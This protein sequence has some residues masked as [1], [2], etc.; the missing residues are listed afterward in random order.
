[1]SDKL[2]QIDQLQR[3][4]TDEAFKAAGLPADGWAR[5]LFGPLLKPPTRRFARLASEFD[6]TVNRIGLSAAAGDFLS[7]FVEGVVVCG[8]E[9]IPVDGP[10]LI[11]SNHPGTLDGFVILSNLPRADVKLVISGVPFV[12]AFPSLE[13]HL[14]YTTGD[15]H[16]R[17]GVVRSGIRCLRGGGALM[18]FPT[19]ILD[20]DPAILSGAEEALGKWSRSLEIFLRSVPET[21]IL[22]TIVSGVLAP[23]CLRNP[24]T[25]MRR[26]FWQQQRIAEYIQVSQMVF[27]ERKYDLSP[28]VSFAAPVTVEA[29]RLEDGSE[30]ITKAI[31]DM[32]RGLLA[33]HIG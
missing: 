20:P 16:E 7:R 5:W 14:I 8:A 28:K 9:N 26:T 10:L 6:H 13:E 2:L 29:L 21:K 25:K 32:A 3:T 11:A 22:V 27:S 19:G 30:G 33:N 15:P 17:I 31:I 4:I 12:R 18:L 23:E 24:L 1:M